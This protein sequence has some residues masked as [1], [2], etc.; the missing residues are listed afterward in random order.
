MELI[1]R[2]LVRQQLIFVVFVFQNLIKV[3]EFVTLVSMYA[4]KKVK[5]VNKIDLIMFVYFTNTIRSSLSI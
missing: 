4:V 3:R 5:Q 2:L 1:K